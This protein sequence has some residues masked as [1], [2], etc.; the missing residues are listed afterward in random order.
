MNNEKTKIPSFDDE[1]IKG[2][3]DYVNTASQEGLV[4]S[5]FDNWD[6]ANDSLGF[7]DDQKWILAITREQIKPISKNS[8]RPENIEALKKFFKIYDLNPTTNSELKSIRKSLI[9]IKTTTGYDY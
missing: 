2:I 9:G 1:E 6:A 4:E 7:D 5:F 3:M 8:H